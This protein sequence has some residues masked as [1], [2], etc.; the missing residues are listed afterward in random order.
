MLLIIIPYFGFRVL[1]EALGE[2]RLTR[3]FFIKRGAV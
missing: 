1:D 3:M 2:G